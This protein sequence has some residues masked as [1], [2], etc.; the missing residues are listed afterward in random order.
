VGRLGCVGI[1]QLG[2]GAAAARKQRGM[3]AAA[4]SSGTEQRRLIGIIKRQAC[5]GYRDA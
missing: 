1:E 5:R 2:A 3:E 4:A